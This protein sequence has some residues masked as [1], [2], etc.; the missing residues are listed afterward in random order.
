MTLAGFVFGMIVSSLYGALFH[1]WRGGSLGK[2][3][4][5]LVLGWAGF[6]GGQIAVVT[7]GLRIW[8]VGPIYLGTATIFCALLLGLGYWLG[9]V[10]R[11]E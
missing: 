6:W 8:Q 3:L 5:Y 1:F 9:L 2:L 10:N 11:R 7:T 4:L